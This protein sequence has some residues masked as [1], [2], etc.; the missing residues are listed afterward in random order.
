M[1]LHENTFGYII[2]TAEQ[3]KTMEKLRAAAKQYA[4]ILEAAL[5]VCSDTYYILQKLREVAM[6]VNVAVTRFPDGSPR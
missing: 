1:I 3:K 5:P 2:P 6:W 4:D